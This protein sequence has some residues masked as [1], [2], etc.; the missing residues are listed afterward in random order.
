VIGTAEGRWTRVNVD[1]EAGLR[2]SQIRMAE[3]GLA[4]IRKVVFTEKEKLFR[5]DHDGRDSG[6][7]SF[8]R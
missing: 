6:G 2:L 7:V 5:L 4:W 8:N 3:F 1:K